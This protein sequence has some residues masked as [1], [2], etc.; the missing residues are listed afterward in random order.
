MDIPVHSLEQHLL[1]PQQ[2][3]PMAG[4]RQSS[5]VQPLCIC[6]RGDEGIDCEVGQRLSVMVTAAVPGSWGRCIDWP[7]GLLSHGPTAESKVCEEEGKQIW[8]AR[9]R[10]TGLQRSRCFLGPCW[11]ALPTWLTTPEGPRLKLHDES[12]TGRRNIRGNMNF[13]MLKGLKC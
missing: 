3:Y 7:A 12:S 11:R 1:S 2:R 10:A 6:A 13:P 8:R 5:T 9:S 4:E